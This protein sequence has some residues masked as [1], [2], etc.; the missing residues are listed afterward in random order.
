MCQ[1][2]EEMLLT[3]CFIMDMAMLSNPA[4]LPAEGLHAMSIIS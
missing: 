2:I 1:R 4:D 3:D